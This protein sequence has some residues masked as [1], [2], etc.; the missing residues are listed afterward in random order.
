MPKSK[1][2][3]PPPRRTDQATPG[4]SPAAVRAWFTK[5]A[6]KKGAP[7]ARSEYHPLGPPTYCWTNAWLYANE[8][9][10]GYA[11]GVVTMPNGTHAHAWV[12]AADGTAIEV[13]K[14]YDIATGYRGWVLDK[15]RVAA[16]SSTMGLDR[17]SILESAYASG[18]APWPVILAHLTG[19]R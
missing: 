19:R 17:S 18:A 9:D 5:T 11:E 7:F 1:T 8:H 16:G 15:D 3:K 14:G 12:V 4:M 13:T 6:T 10:L 2:R